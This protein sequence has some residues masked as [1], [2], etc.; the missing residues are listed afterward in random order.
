MAIMASPGSDI[1]LVDERMEGYRAFA[2]KLWNA[3]R[4]ALMRLGDAGEKLEFSAT[5][6]SLVDRWIL[7]RADRLVQEVDRA[8]EQFRVD[9]ASDALYHFVWH[10]FCDWY[11]EFV[12]PDLVA[13]GDGNRAETAKAVLQSVLDRLLRM[14][15]PF[16]PF[17]TEELWGKLPRDASCLSVASWPSTD[18]SWI[19]DAAENSVQRIQ[20][21]IARVRSM[22][23]ESRIDPGKR[24]E[25]TVLPASDDLGELFQS[26][27]RLIGV[28]T[29]A[30]RINVA[31]RF[32]E[33][34]IAVKGVGNGFEVAIPLEGLLD[35]DAERNR[36]AKELARV[37]NDLQKREKKLDN[38]SF[39]KRAPAEVV[40]KERTICSELREKA[41][42]FRS[43]LENLKGGEGR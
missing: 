42:R 43:S 34:R 36:L 12:K 19:D 21:L 16:M 7:S 40:E 23:A 28:L 17:I 24:I 31:D 41:I 22:R 4:F 8:L 25:F 11:I 5:E 14:L 18:S 27:S 15:H 35:L 29:R 2:N 39:L 1:P 9:R 20:D 37:E 38:R 33:G 10:E 6:L 13:D 26:E 3:C 30:S 32:E